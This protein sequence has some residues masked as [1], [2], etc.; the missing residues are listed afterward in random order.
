M[1]ISFCS[2]RDMRVTK[3]PRVARLHSFLKCRKG[4][5]SSFDRKAA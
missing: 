5:E 2:A 4:G 1:W 3:C